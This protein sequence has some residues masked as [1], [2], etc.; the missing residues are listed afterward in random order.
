VK[1]IKQSDFARLHG[2]SRNSVTKWKARGWLTF[3]GD[4]VDVE[5]SNALLK[6]YR[7]DGDMRVTPPG[8]SLS[9]SPVA[10]RRVPRAEIRPEDGE[11]A[12]EAAERIALGAA[13]HSYDEARRIKENY[14]ALLNQLE[15]DERAGAVVAVKDVAGAVGSALAKVR[16]R[17]LA[18]PS[19]QA[20][21]LARLKTAAEVQDALQTIITNA[22]EEL[23][24]LAAKTT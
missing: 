9:P 11:T 14:L 6:K 3:A 19:E 12:E 10:E 15:Y 17:L 1:H 7:R 20:P 16:T 2:V 21:Q 23:V 5:A 22:L 18:I 4:L 24:S 13:P 8:D